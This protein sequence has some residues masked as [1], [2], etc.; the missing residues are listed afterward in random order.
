[1]YWRRG[2]RNRESGVPGGRL[3]KAIISE[4]AV[5]SVA[6]QLEKAHE[7]VQKHIIFCSIN[8]PIYLCYL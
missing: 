5:Q 7:R 4:M 3:M 2:S 8:C 1:M 6:E